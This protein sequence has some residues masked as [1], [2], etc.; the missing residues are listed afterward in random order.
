V[1]VVRRSEQPQ[2]K[3]LQVFP[4][5][6]ISAGIGAHYPSSTAPF[7]FAASARSKPTISF[8]NDN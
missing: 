5:V 2:P 8:L 1:K 3:D 6:A 7:T 4:R